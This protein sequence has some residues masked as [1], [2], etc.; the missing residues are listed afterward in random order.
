MAIHTQGQRLQALQ[1]QER[2]KGAETGAEVAH[3]L[4]TRFHDKGEIAKC[5]PIAHA[6]IARRRLDHFWE[7]AIVPGKR[8]T[9]DDDA[10]DTS[11]MSTNEFGGGVHDNVSPMLKGPTQLARGTAV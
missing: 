2:I 11:A 5:F 4:H 8:P 7:G 6:V 10:T 3:H 9:I 1:K